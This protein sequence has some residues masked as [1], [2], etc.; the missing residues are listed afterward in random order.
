MV[1]NDRGAGGISNHSNA[2]LYYLVVAG[3]SERPS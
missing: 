1:I 2:M 3:S